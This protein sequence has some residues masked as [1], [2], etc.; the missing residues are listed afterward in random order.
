WP[1]GGASLALASQGAGLW[2]VLE[3]ADGP[4]LWQRDNDGAWSDHGLLP[5]GPDPAS[6]RALGQAHL[7][8]LQRGE[9]NVAL[10]RYR[11]VTRSW[12]SQP[13]DLPAAAR[14]AAGGKGLFWVDAG[15]GAAG[16]TG[17]G[18]GEHLLRAT[19]WVGLALYM[20]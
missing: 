6:L 14:V 18:P 8:F 1:G 3:G 17:F 12:A 9:G 20:A 2:L 5:A 11:V 19:D 16:T 13:G 7:L 10:A 4:R 15:S